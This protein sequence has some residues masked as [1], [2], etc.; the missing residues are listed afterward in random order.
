MMELQYVRTDRNGTKYFYDWNC[1]RCGG[2]GESDNW[3]RTG[4]TCFECGGSGRRNTPKTVKE[5]T[6]EYEAKLMAKRVAKRAK[7]EAE[8]AEEIEQEKTRVAD[9]MRRMRIV[10][11]YDHG[12]NDDGIG[13]VLTG[14]TYKIKEQIKAQGGRWTCGVW[15]CPVEIKCVGVTATKIDMN[16]DEDLCEIIWNATH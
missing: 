8:H 3:Y 13:Y 14:N 2:A 1:P 6:P 10:N 4:R 12:C 9:H 7:Y 15:V 5:Y 16:S 11:F